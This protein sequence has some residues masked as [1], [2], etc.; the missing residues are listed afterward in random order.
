MTEQQVLDEQAY[1]DG[2]SEE[3]M[4]VIE[5]E[6]EDLDVLGE[7]DYID[8]ADYA[9]SEYYE[10]EYYEE[11]DV[12]YA[13]EAYD[14]SVEY[15]E[16]GEYYEDAVYDESSE[17]A[18][19]DEAAYE[20]PVSEEPVYEEPAYEEAVSEEV[21]EEPVT[22]KTVRTNFNTEQIADIG[23]A[24]EAQADMASR[25]AYEEI[26]DEYVPSKERE[27][28]VDEQELFA[29]FLYSKKMSNQ[30]LKAIEQI[31]LASYVGNV[32]ITGESSTNVLNLAK[33]VIKEI[34]MTDGN[35]VASKVAKISG[36]KM[37]QK[38]ISD[39]SC[40]FRAELLL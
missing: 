6:S 12:A 38:D 37:N 11:G 10:D 27:L 3:E 18:T 23:N 22:D 24:L 13:D 20:E 9:D 1:A 26:N 30:I 32:I 8:G 35:F 14:E 21:V 2:A 33:A 28:T 34:Q 16:D 15:A 25:K 5:G 4:P 17:Q 19:Y 39:F 36:N 7:Q 40:S 31:S 29:D